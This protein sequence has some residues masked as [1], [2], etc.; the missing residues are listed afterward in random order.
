[1]PTW[2]ELV[3]RAGKYIVCMLDQ[4]EKAPTYGA[5]NKLIGKKS[6]SKR[7][8]QQACMANLKLVNEVSQM[9]YQADVIS[10]EE[11]VK[12]PKATI[13]QIQP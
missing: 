7:D 8:V 2:E 10:F 1:M 3:E 12:M 11:D 9:L 4:H 5:Y 13:N 6:T